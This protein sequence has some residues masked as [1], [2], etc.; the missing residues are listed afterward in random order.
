MSMIMWR[1]RTKLRGALI[2][3]AVGS[4]CVAAPAA[5]EVGH[6]YISIA[7]IPGDARVDAYRD[8]IRLEGRYWGTKTPAPPKGTGSIVAQP[9]FSVPLAPQTGTGE[10]VV[11]LDKKN[12]ALK[13]LMERCIKGTPIT[14]LRFAESADD[15]RSS[16]HE[17]GDRPARIPPYFEYRLKNVKISACPVSP[18]AP[19]QGLVLAFGGIEWL[20]YT[21]DNSRL[22][23]GARLGRGV[24]RKAEKLELTSLHLAPPPPG[25]VKTFVTSWLGVAN[26]V[27][28][29]QCPHL[30]HK[31]LPK[32]FG[33]PDV[34]PDETGAG[35]LTNPLENRAAGGLNACLLPGLL[36]DPGTAEP[37]TKVAR[38][39]NLDDHD[40]TGKFPATTC[41]HRNY[42]TDSGETG[43]DN[44][45]YG[46][47]GCISG[48]QGKQ[49]LWQQVLNEEWRSGAVSLIFQVFGI[50]DDQNDDQVEIRISYSEDDPEKDAGGKQILADYTF[51][52]STKPQ[53]THFFAAFP[54]RIVNGVIESEKIDRLVL[55]MVKG[56][57]IRLADA[58]LRLRINAQGNL[59]G[60]MAGYENWRYLANYYNF[61]GFEITFGFQCPA[62]YNALKRGADGM[63]N[64]ETGEFEGIS[65]A[66]DIEAIPAFLPLAE[67]TPES[68]RSTFDAN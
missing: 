63:Q 55:N 29:T 40:G 57:A 68:H 48:L 28:K 5:A 14:E 53:L 46:V 19:E 26:D 11:A 23:D 21:L 20:N 25:A 54:A 51:R 47:S 66:Y 9:I 7:G 42:N 43:I 2:L 59:T 58:K 24:L 35:S 3:G 27:S 64:P 56:P 4:G 16:A 62:F 32:D 31:P 13:T 1:N 34:A 36:P 33:M 41:P 6:A 17:L 22:T 67:L 39:L 52:P 8:W 15:F 12:P 60:I 44:Q 37:Q 65:V 61:I 50:D 18:G 10:L 45:F 38:G 49:G 30:N